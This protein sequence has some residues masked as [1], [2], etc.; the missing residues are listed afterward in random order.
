MSGAAP[1]VG[2]GAAPLLGQGGAPRPPVPRVPV[3]A[4]HH[5]HDGE[6]SFFRTWP[7]A[8]R[9]QMELLLDTGRVPATPDR[10][11]ALAG[12]EA[13]PEPLVLVTFDDA[14]VDFL[15]HA[16]PVLDRLGIPATVFVVVDAIGGWNDWD[17]T[18]PARHRHLGADDLRRLHAAGVTIGSHTCSHRPLVRLSGAEL[19]DELATSRRR[20][21]DLLG[22]PVASF[23]Y[24]GGAAGERE[25]LAAARRYDVAFAFG[26]GAP[27]SHD[28]PFLVPRFDPCFHQGPE[29]FLAQLALHSGPVGGPRRTP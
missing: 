13:A 9:R 6:D 1:L 7:D 14:Y 29:D 8:F 17:D 12:A 22:A 23:A 16:W 25:R 27:G 11:A 20:L 4:Y 24:P 15:D 5:V 3:L 21:E 19:D 2:E 28:D 18:A 10:L 26:P